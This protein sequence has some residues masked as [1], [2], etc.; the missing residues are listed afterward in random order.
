MRW[1]VYGV[2]ALGITIA[3]LMGCGQQPVGAVGA[4][5]PGW[6]CWVGDRMIPVRDVESPV[7]YQGSGRAVWRLTRTDGTRIQ[8]SEAVCEENR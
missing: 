2:G 6:T 7:F 4:A 5:H 1:I 8:A 3:G